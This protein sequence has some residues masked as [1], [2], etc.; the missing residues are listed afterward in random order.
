MRASAKMMVVL[1]VLLKPIA[2]K[3]GK[4]QGFFPA[5]ADHQDFMA[6]NP[7][8]PYIVYNDRPK[9]EALKRMFPQA[10]KS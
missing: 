1:H 7:N 5:E 6:R 4:Q 9:V 10:W 3:L 8:Y 2:T